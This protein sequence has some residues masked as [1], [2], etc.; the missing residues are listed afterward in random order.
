MITASSKESLSSPDTQNTTFC[1]LC[2]FYF[3]LVS[4]IEFLSLS[5]FFFFWL[6]QMA[7]GLLVLQSG[8]K[9]V[10]LAVEAWSFNH[11]TAGEVP[12]LSDL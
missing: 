1:C 3:F 11:W 10:P 7:C 8:I 2:A 12:H 4:V 5:F 6:Y 9:P